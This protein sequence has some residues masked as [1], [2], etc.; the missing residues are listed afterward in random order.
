MVRTT[1]LLAAFLSMSIG[2][3]AHAA[4]SQATLQAWGSHEIELTPNR[5]EFSAQIQ[6]ES[7]DLKQAL[8][9]LQATVDLTEKRL[10]T[11]G[12]VP[13]SLEWNTPQV[14]RRKVQ[15]VMPG[16]V[17]TTGGSTIWSTPNG[18][19]AGSA[20]GSAPV[21][22]VEITVYH[23]SRSFRA[24]FALEETTEAELLLEAYSIVDRV[25]AADKPREEGDIAI[26]TPAAQGYQSGYATGAAYAAP[27]N[28][29]SVPYQSNYTPAP[30]S[31][32][33]RPPAS[34]AALTWKWV[35]EITPEQKQS[36]TAAAFAKAKSNAQAA[37][38]VA[39]ATSSVRLAR[40]DD[41]GG[42]AMSSNGLSPMPEADALN[43]RV[44]RPITTSPSELKEHFSASGQF[45]FDVE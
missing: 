18:P 9:Q 23:V 42:F 28:Y 34:N 4:D 13:D 15:Q 17:P 8:T 38:D 45:V 40:L 7:P 2:A 30:T 3:A 19:K 22:T 29:P 27:P 11:L 10:G 37:A 20:F 16:T 6:T 35:A 5:L 36:A 25:E 14:S 12:M 43:Q 31:V 1:V 26:W 21:K 24:D 39:G 33:Y 41:A 44:T 32:I